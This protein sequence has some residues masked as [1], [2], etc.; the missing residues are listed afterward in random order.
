MSS[1]SRATRENQKQLY[2]GRL[3]ARQG[4]LEKRG[5]AA[6]D[7][8]KDKVY[9]HLKARH[10]AILKAIAAIDNL[11]RRA[12]PE[13][14]EASK[15]EPAPAAAEKKQKKEKAEKQEKPA[16]PAKAAKAPAAGAGK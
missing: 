9:Q 5:M 13:V 16:K 7:F 3:Q 11:A 15:P 14:K 1:Q 2:E 4:V 10:E 12:Q 6:A 8:K